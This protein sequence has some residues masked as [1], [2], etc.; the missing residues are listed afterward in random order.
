MFSMSRSGGGR[1]R[2]QKN[3][4]VGIKNNLS[5]KT[6]Y[7]EHERRRGITPVHVSCV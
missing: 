4:M 3:A 7:E 6:E 5:K 2:Q 1:D